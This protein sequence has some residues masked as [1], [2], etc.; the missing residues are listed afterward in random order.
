MSGKQ[1]KK[2][3]RAMK[4][5]G[6]QTNGREHFI[7]GKK[8]MMTMT[9]EMYRRAYNRARTIFDMKDRVNYIRSIPAIGAKFEVV[10]D[11]HVVCD[12]KRRMY[13]EYKKVLR[14]NNRGG[15]NGHEAVRGDLRRNT[16]SNPVE[17]VPS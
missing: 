15:G 1:M 13:Q 9:E 11:K 17:A 7:V 16:T 10:L 12:D 6:V 4:A 2:L 3:R 8:T 5:A 14:E